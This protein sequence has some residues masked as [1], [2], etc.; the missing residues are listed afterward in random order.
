MPPFAG[1]LSAQLAS[2]CGSLRS[3]DQED[4]D[5]KKTDWAMAPMAFNILRK[6]FS[7]PPKDTDM[8]WLEAANGR[9]WPIGA[10][11][12]LGRSKDN[13]VLVEDQAVS[14]RHALINK[15]GEAEY[16]I[17]D[18]GSGNGTALND[19]RVTLAT[20]LKNSDVLRLGEH[21]F[22]FRQLSAATAARR[23]GPAPT[24]TVINIK[25]VPLWLLVADIKGSTTLAA[26]LP[27]ADMAMMV[28]R[29]LDICSHDVIEAHGGT[30]N[31]YLGDGFLA[32]WPVEPDGAA[33]PCLAALEQLL[34]MQRSAQKPRFRLALHLGQVAIG[35]GGAQGEDSLTGLDLIFV[36][37]M[38][39]LA[40]QLG[41]DFLVS[42]AARRRLANAL[43]FAD[44]GA[45]VLPGIDGG[46]HRFFTVA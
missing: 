44:G 17:I 43:P 38:E 20:R 15:Q 24:E 14:R 41:C 3:H 36:F 28:G 18:L 26:Q 42:D 23:D 6:I 5:T 13:N 29:W 8:A 32:Y 22:T 33:P 10:S 46:A 12:S 25:T 37:R 40:G 7:T 16:W 21:T 9:R 45:H 11:C 35:G 19:R 31:K 1:R 27:P 34:T 30:L 2:R 4:F 39:K